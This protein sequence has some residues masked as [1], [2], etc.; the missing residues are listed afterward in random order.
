MF[1]LILFLSIY[2]ARFAESAAG[3]YYTG[4]VDAIQACNGSTPI[5]CW[6]PSS[7]FECA[8]TIGDCWLTVCPNQRPYMCFTSGKCVTDFAY[9]LDCPADKPYRCDYDQSCSATAADCPVA[10][11]DTGAILRTTYRGR[12]GVLLDDYPTADGYRERI[13]QFYLDIIDREYWINRVIARDTLM[14]YQQSFQSFFQVDKLGLTLPPDTLWD[15]AVK[16]SDDPEEINVYPY[17]RT[18]DGHDMIV[19][20]YLFDGYVIGTE[21]SI[22]YS[23]SKLIPI[24]GKVHMSYVLPVDDTLLFAKT[25]YACMDEAEYPLYSVT[26]QNADK[27]YDDSCGVEDPLVP[28]CHFT[29]QPTRSC[30]NAVKEELGSFR[31]TVTWERVAWSDDIANEWRYPSNNVGITETVNMLPVQSEFDDIQIRWQYVQPDACGLETGEQGCFKAPGWR[32]RLDFGSSSTN[33]G[34]NELLMGVALYGP[35]AKLGIYDYSPCHQ[36][37][38][39]NQYA[40]FSYGTDEARKTAFCLISTTRRNNNEFTPFGSE[41]SSCVR[42]GVTPGWSDDYYSGIACQHIDITDTAPGTQLLREHQNPRGFMCEGTPE[43]DPVSKKLKFIETGNLLENGDKEYKQACTYTPNYDADNFEQVS[44][45]KPSG[46]GTSVTDPCL[47]KENGYQRDCG[48]TLFSANT[49]CVPGQQTTVSLRVN[50]D[51]LMA[52]RVCD[53]SIVQN[54]PL[55]CH[56]QIALKTQVLLPNVDNH[57]TFTCPVYRDALEIGGHFSLYVAPLHVADELVVPVLLTK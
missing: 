42:Q 34:K 14:R 10:P 36:H 4:S 15:K 37:A 9:C 12:V 30:V 27:F 38:H 55:A 1:L 57:V 43:V 44:V 13:A 52:V 56:D 35:W 21:S 17:R 31:L 5:A 26:A 7:Q 25:G 28:I 11:A 8:A 29:A 48:F 23:D 51:K 16:F 33:M 2:Y 39:F 6:L 20:D 3:D 40:D 19:V 47:E 32:Q 46:G 54:L 49:E 53:F 50:D 18:I 22:P 41:F 45:T 24:R